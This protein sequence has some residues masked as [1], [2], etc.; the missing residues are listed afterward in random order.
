M[1]TN[2][3]NNKK[4]RKTKKNRMTGGEIKMITITFGNYTKEPFSRHGWVDAK[5]EGETIKKGEEFIPHGKGK[6]IYPTENN[7]KNNPDKKK[8]VDRDVLEGDFHINEEGTLITKDGKLTYRDGEIYEGDF[9]SSI[10]DG[11]G[12]MTYS[13]GDTYKGDW[14]LERR[15]GEG[16]LRAKDGTLLY[17]GD[18]KGN[19]PVK[20]ALLRLDEIAANTFFEENKNKKFSHKD[21]SMPIFVVLRQYGYTKKR[22]KSGTHSKTTYSIIKNP[23]LGGGNK[24]A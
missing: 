7:E 15:E 8:P 18:W 2:K 12:T 13:N 20:P 4:I 11:K 21:I 10:R 5:Y 17:K 1:K 24:N 16:E 6:I 23:H 19:K 14:R 9:K 3:K 22:N